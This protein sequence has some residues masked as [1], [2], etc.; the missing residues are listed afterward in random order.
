M[1]FNSSFTDIFRNKCT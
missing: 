1:K